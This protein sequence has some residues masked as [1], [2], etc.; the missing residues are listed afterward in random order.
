[1]SRIYL[2][3]HPGWEFRHAWICAQ[4]LHLWYN[5]FATFQLSSEIYPQLRMGQ[6]L[7]PGTNFRLN[8]FI[9]LQSLILTHSKVYS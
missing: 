3:V 9:N 8:H 5:I 2:A 6:Q 1:M 7:Q 4:N